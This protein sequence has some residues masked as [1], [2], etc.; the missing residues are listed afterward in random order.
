MLC[1]STHGLARY[2]RIDRRCAVN[3]SRKSALRTENLEQTDR[4]LGWA[5]EK[6]QTPGYM[7]GFGFWASEEQPLFVPSF[8]LHVYAYMQPF[9]LRRA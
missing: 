1:T 5:R 8:L 6:Q 4:R 2:Y 3:H 9:E 7:R